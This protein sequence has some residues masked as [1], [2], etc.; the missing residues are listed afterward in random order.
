MR[1]FAGHASGFARGLGSLETSSQS[2][3][4]TASV[5][6]SSASGT[7]GFTKTTTA[8]PITW[9]APKQP[10]SAETVA[11][12]TQGSGSVVSTIVGAVATEKAIAA[13]EYKKKQQRK[14]Q[15]A[16]AASAGA[17]APP[18]AAPMPA[19]SAF[20]GFPV[21]TALLVAAAVGGVYL[22][23]RPSRPAAQLPPAPAAPRSL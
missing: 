12:I 8:T 17:Y 10:L 6:V 22:L 13:A 11:A 20:A 21:T 4:L 23:T 14:K 9:S 5:A 2:A 15:K 1:G 3:G 19:P 18:V 16:A 7:G